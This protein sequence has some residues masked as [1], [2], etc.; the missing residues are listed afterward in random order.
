MY[1]WLQRLNQSED[2]SFT[3]TY[4]FTQIGGSGPATGNNLIIGTGRTP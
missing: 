1:F 4:Q 2:Q 3:L